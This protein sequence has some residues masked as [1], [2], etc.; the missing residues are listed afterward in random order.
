M[1]CKKYRKIESNS[2]K[3]SNNRILYNISSEGEYH[4]SHYKLVDNCLNESLTNIK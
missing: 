3:K 2:R 4:C 1:K